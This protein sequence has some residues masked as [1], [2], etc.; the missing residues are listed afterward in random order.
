[1]R[2][3]AN[4]LEAER[5]LNACKLKKTAPRLLVLSI[6]AEKNMAIASPVLMKKIKDMNR[7]TRYKVLQTLESRGIIY[8]LFNSNGITHYA[9]SQLDPAGVQ[10]VVRLHFNCVKCKKI[11]LLNELNC[12]VPPVPR[13][14]RADKFSIC[15]SGTCSSC[16]ESQVIV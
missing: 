4:K 12:A 6:I 16:S 5:V 15:I 8:K 3:V 13:G 14:F 9:I 1:M 10:P 11:Y 7:S 2:K